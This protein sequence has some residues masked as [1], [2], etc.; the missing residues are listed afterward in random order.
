MSQ[1]A[2]GLPDPAAY[3]RPSAEGASPAMAQWF[4]LKE[5]APDLLLFFRMGDF[6]ELFFDDALAAASALDIALTTRGQQ[7]GAPIP[8]CGVPVSTAQAYLARLI[9]RG[10]RVAVAEQTETPR[11]G[12]K[13][14]LSRAIVRLITPG[15]LTEDELLEPGRAS[16]LF[17]VVL[18]PEETRRGRPS[19]TSAKSLAG[20]AWIDISTGQFETA[21]VTTAALG[22]LLGRLEPAEILAPEG[23]LPPEWE[24]HRAP[25]P[26]LPGAEV[27]GSRLADIFGVSSLDAFGTFSDTELLAGFAT[28]D[29][30]RRSQA[31]TLPRLAHPVPREESGILGLDAATRASLDL[32]RARDGGSDHTLFSATDRTVTAPGA[33]LLARWISAPL[34]DTTAI[35]ERQG[36]WIWLAAQPSLIGA[37]KE[38][39]RGA[40][41]LERALGRLSVGRGQPRDLAA[42]RDALAAART[43]AT[44]LSDANTASPLPP[45]IPG[46]CH[47]LSGGEIVLEELTRALAPD[48]PARVEDGGFIVAGFDADLDAQRSLRD[49]SRRV[50]AGLQT[51]YAETY[52]VSSLKIRHHA[53]LGYVMEVPVAAGTKLRSREDLSFRQGTS[54][55]ARFATEEL[56]ELDRRISG[57]AERALIREQ[58]IFTRLVKLI[59]EEQTLPGI[60]RALA[61]CDVLRS[62]AVLGA[63]SGWCRPD[64]VEQEAFSLT[65]CRH[66]VVEAA[67]PRDSRFTP[68]DC[69]LPPDCRVMLLTGPNMAGKSTFLRQNALAVI[70]AQAGMPVPAEVARIGVVDRLFSRVG[71]ADDLARGRSTF[72]VEMTE[73]AAIL[74]QAGPRSLV[75][76]DEIGRGTATLDGL[77]IA[78]AVL[79][80][81]HSS[82]RCRTIFATHFHELAQL[83]D[84]LPRLSPHTMAVREW[85]GQIVFRHEVIPGSAHRSWGVHVARL[86]GVPLPVVE[87][88]GRLLRELE[89]EN[90]RTQ[91]PLPLFDTMAEA[92]SSATVSE[93]MSELENRIA[94]LDPDSCTPREALEILYDLRKAALEA[95][96]N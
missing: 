13:G 41:D 71:A 58:Q 80:A 33:R 15:T 16:L 6:Y 34:T 29:Y 81:L 35:S 94:Q 88:A 49:D 37:M 40:P 66:P 61:L 68:N 74:N 85:K 56:S 89:R 28:V 77:A 52:G 65:A 4:A 23:I 10:F 2:S 14:P 9:R 19:R 27:A 91:A 11:P 3:I 54:S 18:S 32:L 96:Q 21:Q 55:L 38:A 44:L 24:S 36:G 43:V 84:T 70:L 39:L 25:L 82:I 30:I 60:A 73:T 53:Q 75:V 86:A 17:S 8:M 69:A 87:R 64:V 45:V 20:A 46:L 57:A 31:G 76:V 51:S 48:L 83:A 22:D 79:E 26:A 5:E 47:K 90:A 42:V 59:L 50:V 72:M 78:W 67:L 1:P 93:G 62:C 12:Q 92:S 7:G 63:G 95:R